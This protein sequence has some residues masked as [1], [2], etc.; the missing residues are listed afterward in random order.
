[1]AAREP[2]FIGWEKRLPPHAWLLGTFAVWLIAGMF[3]LALLLP[4][5]AADPGAGDWAGDAELR[6]TLTLRPYP[7][8]ML[9]ADA[10]HPAGRM[11]M[12]SAFG[13]SQVKA[14]GMEGQTVVARGPSIRRGDREML[15]VN[16]PGDMRAEGAAPPMAA[17]VP[18]GR[19]RITG[20]ICDGKCAVGAMRPGTGFAHRACAGLCLIGDVPPMLVSM[21]PVAGET[22]LL[23]AGPDGGPMPAALRRHLAQRIRLDGEVER[24]GDL[25]V[26][27]ADPASLAVL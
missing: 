13:K 8:L 5:T 21:A 2:F 12:L 15:V 1:M 22:F 7:L 10:A 3:A 25:L 18:L 17:P 9:P 19:W 27:R 6:G 4:A 20:E 16:A 23:L 24:R 14:D 11:V 26:F